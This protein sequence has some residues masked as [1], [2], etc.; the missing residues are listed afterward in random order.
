MRIQIE[1]KNYCGTCTLTAAAAVCLQ[2]HGGNFT[3]S[4]GVVC[5]ASTR[6][7]EEGRDVN[8]SVHIRRIT[9]MNQF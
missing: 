6:K 7:E 4:S 8:I 3:V 9:V 5:Y 1:S 2:K